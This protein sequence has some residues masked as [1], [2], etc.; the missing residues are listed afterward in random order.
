MKS[1]YFKPGIAAIVLAVLFPLYWSFLLVFG[2]S[3]E[4][5]SQALRAE[6]TTFDLLDG[7]FILIGVLEVYVYLSLIRSFNERLSS[8]LARATLFIMIGAVVF[9]HCI[10]FVDLYLAIFKSDLTE[11]M[12]DGV[13]EVSTF[14]AISGLVIYIISGLVLSAVLL[15]RGQ[16]L[17]SELKY[18]ALIFLIV[19]LLSAT[20]LLSAINL[21]LFPVAL[22]V[23]AVYFLKDP[24]T[25]EV[26]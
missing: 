12:I 1:S 14:V 3:Y 11:K 5:L 19:C 25:L 21:L 22:I 4:S 16:E 2:P 20:I 17:A 8:S 9:F 6:L 26:V 15:M 24:E 13:I 23:L 18:F 7:L 10:V